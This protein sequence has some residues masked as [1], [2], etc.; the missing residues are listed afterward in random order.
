MSPSSVCS[1]QHHRILSSKNSLSF[2]ASET[3]YSLVVGCFLSL[4]AQSDS[5]STQ[6]LGVAVYYP[7]LP[8][9]ASFFMLMASTV[10]YNWLGNWCP[11]PRL[12][13]QLQICM[14]ICLLDISFAVSKLAHIQLIIFLPL[15]S[16]QA[17]IPVFCVSVNGSII[18]LI[19]WVR[20]TKFTLETS[21]FSITSEA[22]QQIFLI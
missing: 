5:S 17:D 21:P 16:P 3:W 19:T 13:P 2:L 20:N 7:I 8:H 6:L 9:L 1:I 22:H 10:I 12:L 18:Q 11:Q 15:L 4:S 14:F